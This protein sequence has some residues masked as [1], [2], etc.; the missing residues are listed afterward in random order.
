MR[1]FIVLTTFFIIG[2]FLLVASFA[3]NFDRS[4][5][6]D[7]ERL[8]KAYPISVRIDIDLIKSLGPAYE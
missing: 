8:A 5:Y 7:E 4:K 1:N 3:F 2:F 6:I